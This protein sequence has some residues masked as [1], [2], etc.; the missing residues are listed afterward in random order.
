MKEIASNHLQRHSIGIFDSGLGGLSV[1]KAINH[2]LPL[3]SIIYYA[4]SLHAPYGS[5]PDEFIIE[6]CETIAAWLFSQNIKILV[7][8]CNTATALIINRLR[9]LWPFP[10]VGIEPGLKPAVNLSKNK[11]VGVLATEA[12]LR[13]DRFQNLK[14]R[15]SSEC[16]FV[17]IP[18]YGLVEIVENGEN[19]LNTTLKLVKKYCDQLI[20][21]NA[22]VLVLGCTHYPFLSSIFQIFINNKM[23][24]IDTSCAVALHCRNSL[25]FLNNNLDQGKVFLY[26]SGN[27]ESLQ[28]MAK[29][30]LSCQCV[31][32]YKNI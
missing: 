22:D 9:M 32:S 14:K 3:E 12:T 11:R 8:A 31:I 15:F 27:L 21:A 20:Q 5:K 23:V 19:N 10:I 4:D 24:M 6:R 29:K 26:S 13:S 17:C 1:L 18:A 16:E 2:L 7:V 28:V 30:L 25:P